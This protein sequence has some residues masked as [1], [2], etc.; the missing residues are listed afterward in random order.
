MTA[1]GP[2]PP[3][4]QE[5]QMVTLLKAGEVMVA[6]S[7][8]LRLGVFSRDRF[9]IGLI[10][11]KTHKYARIWFPETMW[12]LNEV[13]VQAAAT[14]DG[15]ITAFFFNR[16]EADTPE[17]EIFNVRLPS[18]SRRAYVDLKV[19]V[20]SKKADR[21]SKEASSATNDDG[22]TRIDVPGSL[23]LKIEPMA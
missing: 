19:A 14:A 17:N 22:W 2:F 1:A 9:H 7:S 21:F 8:R 12:S 13:R 11:Q 18:S 4:L 20:T 10:D 5:Y 6:A 23:K 15:S 3:V 16:V